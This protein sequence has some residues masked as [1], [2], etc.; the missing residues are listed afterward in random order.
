MYDSLYSECF[1]ALGL[2]SANPAIC[3]TPWRRDVSTPLR[4]TD[5]WAELHLMC[6]TQFASGA[7]MLQGDEMGIPGKIREIEVSG[8]K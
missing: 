8:W 5:C 7:G 3:S 2:H 1:T 6:A 4:I